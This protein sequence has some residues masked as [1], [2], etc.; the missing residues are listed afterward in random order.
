[1]GPNMAYGQARSLVFLEIHTY[2]HVATILPI[3]FI[4]IHI[5]II[6]KQINKKS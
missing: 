3:L 5:H 4:L 2:A 6:N 1:M